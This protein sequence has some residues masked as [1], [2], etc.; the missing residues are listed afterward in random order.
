M[1]TAFYYQPKKKT[2][3][4]VIYEVSP[5]FY[6]WQKGGVRGGH[7]KQSVGKARTQI[8]RDHDDNNTN[9]AN[10]DQALSERPLPIPLIQS[11]INRG[12]IS[13]KKSWVM[14]VMMALESTARILRGRPPP[15]P[16]Y[17]DNK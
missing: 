11:F 6:M 14:F 3:R 12:D 1:K 13:E 15:P 16:P 5:P 17:W 8:G 9:N 4:Y 7:V 2:F 10:D